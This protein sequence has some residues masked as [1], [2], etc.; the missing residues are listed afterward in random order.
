MTDKKELRD[1]QGSQG[2]EVVKMLLRAGEGA[3]V[4]SPE[5]SISTCA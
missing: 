4:G 5:P 2:N 1:A 3:A